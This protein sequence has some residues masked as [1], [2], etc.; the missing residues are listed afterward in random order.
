[1]GA[2]L[3]EQVPK[4]QALQERTEDAGMALRQ[5]AGSAAKMAGRA[6]RRQAEGSWQGDQS[7]AVAATARALQ[8]SAPVARRY[9]GAR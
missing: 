8:A 5:V 7:A 1:M 4:V 9:Y 3:E 6:P 2:E